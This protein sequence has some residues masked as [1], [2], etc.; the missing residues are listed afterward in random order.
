MAGVLDAVGAESGAGADG[1]DEGAV[2]SPVGVAVT[3]GSGP[4]W[5]PAPLASAGSARIQPGDSTSGSVSR[6][7][8]GCT[9]PSLSSKI[10]W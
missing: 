10:S 6:P 9:R 8:S 7:P 3:F 5:T 1:T 4:V 2:G